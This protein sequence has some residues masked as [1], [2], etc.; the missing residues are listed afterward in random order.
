MQADLIFLQ[1]NRSDRLVVF[2]NY[3]GNDSLDIQITTDALDFDYVPGLRL[4]LGHCQSACRRVELTYLGVVGW[5]ESQRTAI[6]EGYGNWFVLGDQTDVGPTGTFRQRDESNLHSLELNQFF[7]SSPNAWDLLIGARYVYFGD[8][9]VHAFNTADNSYGEFNAM[10]TQ[11][12]LLGLQAGAGRNWSTGLLDVGV[13]GKAGLALN[14]ADMD[15]AHFNP[16][17]GP[18]GIPASSFQASESSVDLSTFLELALDLSCEIYPG[19]DLRTCYRVLVL[20]GIA[21]AP[22]Q[23]E[24]LCNGVVRRNLTP[25]VH[26]TT[27]GDD[28]LLILD[29]FW[30][31]LNYT[32]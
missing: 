15:I 1:R 7:K 26:G 17:S 9:Y 27:I 10:D 25:G 22:S 23:L 4:T 29:G 6:N 18:M 30:I 14:I 32:R 11:N 19:V 3:P 8:E 20:N 16:A 2:N 12:H 24:S 13:S 5:E 21:D 31:G 28:G